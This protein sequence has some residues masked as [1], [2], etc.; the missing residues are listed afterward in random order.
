[1]CI[2]TS[3]FI[4]IFSIFATEILL[5]ILTD[6]KSTVVLIHKKA[7]L[8]APSQPLT[9]GV[10]WVTC[11]ARAQGRRECEFLLLF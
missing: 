3:H 1:M 11:Q 7:L 2:I 9:I 5:P 4:L 8:K 6:V 10:S